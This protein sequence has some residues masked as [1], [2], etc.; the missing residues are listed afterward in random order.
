MSLKSDLS[1]SLI[2]LKL[3]FDSKANTDS[4]QS[5][6]L[7][8][9]SELHLILIY[10]FRQHAFQRSRRRQQLQDLSR[11]PQRQPAQG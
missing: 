3:S 10:P 1:V 2:F 7:P 5:S 6:D 11:H 9:T 4:V 8:E